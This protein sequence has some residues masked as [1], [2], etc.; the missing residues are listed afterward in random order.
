[1]DKETY[2]KIGGHVGKWNGKPR[3]ITIAIHI[4][5]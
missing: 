1:M 5:K 3:A 2:I 4:K